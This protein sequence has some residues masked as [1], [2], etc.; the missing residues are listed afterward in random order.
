[1]ISSFKLK[2]LPS[3]NFGACSIDSLPDITLSFGTNVLII[4][5]SGFRKRLNQWTFI[6]DKLLR[7][8]ATLSYARISSEPGPDEIDA[9]VA[10][11]RPVDPDVVIA[12]GGGSVMDGGKAVSAMLPAGDLI[13]HYLEGVGH[14]QP[15]GQKTP[16]IA[17]PTTAGT[18][19]EAT[20]NAVITRLGSNGYKKS[21]RH[22]RYIPDHTVIDP[23]LMRSCP[24][25]LTASCSMDTFT[26]LVEGFLSTGATAVTDALAWEGLNAVRRSLLT[27]Y[28]DG[29]NIDAR[30][31]MAFAS[32]CSGIV[33]ANA[34][35]GIIH[36]L[37]PALGSLLAIPHG[38]ACGT[39][40]ASGNEVTFNK[41]LEDTQPDTSSTESFLSKYDRLGRLFCTDL[42]D[43]EKPGRMFID[44]LYNIT[45]ELDLPRLT[46]YGVTSDTLD[47]I[48]S[49]S[50]NKNNPVALDSGEIRSIVEKRL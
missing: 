8:K 49:S 13:E 1:M 40:M 24:Q 9:I 33:L 10:Q 5:G 2:P 39:L 46:E 18:G 29:S 15:T 38:A 14:K 47:E 16:F 42:P 32:L 25:P 4:T 11:Y 28:H 17:V 12:I 26:Q 50:S 7:L 21:L 45:D 34:G 43:R 30:T 23:E 41:L 37:A 6:E 36:G 27:V 48:V 20:A 31:D 19:S 35:L 3:I 44:Y 22:D